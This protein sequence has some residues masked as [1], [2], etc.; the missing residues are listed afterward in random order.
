MGSMKL[1]LEYDAAVPQLTV[2]L[3][4][5][6]LYPTRLRGFADGE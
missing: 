3:M 4:H 2:T 5:L 6:L 1:D